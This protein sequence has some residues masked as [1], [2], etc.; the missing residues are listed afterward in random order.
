MRRR[1]LG[2]TLKASVLA[3][4]L[5]VARVAVAGVP[6]AFVDELVTGV[7]APTDVAFLP[8]GRMLATS[9][10]GT[11]YLFPPPY[12]S[13]TVALSFGASV[14]CS[15]VERGLLG[16]A[17]DPAFAANGYVYLYHTFQKPGTTGCPTGSAGVVNR[18]SRFT[19]SP[20]TGST[21]DAAS[22]LV[23]IDNIPSWGGNHNAGDLTF[24]RDGY[25]YISVG[26]SGSDYAGDSGAGGAND[27]SRDTFI[28]LGKILRIDP[29]GATP[30]ARIPAT[31]P[32]QGPDAEPCAAAGRT[33]TP[34]KT[35][36][37]ET[38]ARGLRNPFRFAFD[39]SSVASRFFINDVGQDT[40]EEIDEGQAGADYGWNCREGANVNPQAGSKCQPPPPG[41]VDPIFEYQHGVQVPGTTSPTSCDAITGGAFVPAGSWPTSY[42]GTYLFA[43]F[44]CG[45][46]FQMRP[47]AGGGYQAVDFATNLGGS[48]ATSLTFGPSGV[49][50]TQALYYTSYGGGGQVRRIRYTGSANR[51]P[52]AVLSAT[53]RSGLPPLAVAFDGTGSSDPDTGDAV[54]AWVWDFGDGSPVA[55]TTVPTTSHTYGQGT[56]TAVLRVRDSHGALSDPAT[57]VIDATNHP[58][59]PSIT[60]PSASLRFRVGQSITLVGSATDP[61]DGPLPDGALSWSVLVHTDSQTL[62]LLGPVSG[63]DV[64]FTA[65][66]PESLASAATSYLEIRLTATDSLAATATATQSLLPHTVDVTLATAPAGLQVEANQT[67]FPA[68]RTL[69]SWEGYVLDVNAPHQVDASGNGQT[70]VS[71]SDAGAQSHAITTPALATTYTATFQ[72]GPV[73]LAGDAGIREGDVGTRNVVLPVRLSNPSGAPVSV[74]YATTD[75]TA[76]AG[77]D[78]QAASGLLTFPPGVT[79]QTV[80]VTVF[81]NTTVQPDRRFFL[82]L[83][84]ASGAAIANGRAVGTIVD[85]DAPA[86]DLNRD[87]KPDLLW[88]NQKTGDLYAWFLDG[89]TAAMSSYLT[90]RSIMATQW[91]VRGLVDMDDD[92]ATDVLWQDQTTGNLFVWFMSGTQAVRGSYLSPRGVGDAAW[93]IEAV[94]DL[95]NNGT[96]DILWH[97]QKTGDLYAW[98]LEGTSVKAGAF[99][100]PRRVDP[101]WQVRGVADFDQDG[102]LDL[103]WQN[104]KTGE[105]Y[106]WFMN[107]TTVPRAS[108]LSPRMADTNWKVVQVA[109]FDRDGHPDLLWRNQM[110]G[111]LYVWF[112]DG[113]T[114][115]RA[116]FLTPRSVMD[117]AWQIVPR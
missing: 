13:G 17:V 7:G 24:G 98:F 22:E 88:H 54:A 116:S 49:G 10:G 55:Q 27:A 5:G 39:P 46:V 16:V 73:L 97:N 93:Q 38:F 4:A 66:P 48:S 14:L 34:G 94:A 117:P 115:T 50:G 32:F 58:P 45:W 11:L 101:S 8:D 25:L 83:S 2:F 114:V 47:A 75:G 78:Y 111:D 61:E 57:V 1:E 113:T 96:P 76:H 92:G 6:A 65:P 23:L 44:I 81:G 70:F 104:Q 102:W 107:G 20:P 106:V 53:P 59:V 56:F 62:P 85:D 108:F 80:A 26:D 77:T 112:M 12:T 15:N 28:L 103:L 64:T 40:W 51:A 29:R 90:P 37:M 36:C 69:V 35:Q 18:V 110:S 74:S 21:V 63:N 84:S 86:V 30:A 43:D 100:G 105:Q 33:T 87:L 99:V 91:Q 52:V 41:M 3:A 72:P 67:S 79:G 68:P 60:S 71:W 89:T 109:D 42:D 19:F 82:D 9:Q 95:D 31:N